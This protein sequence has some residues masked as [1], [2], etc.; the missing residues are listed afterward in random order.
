MF[1][2]IVSGGVSFF[3]FRKGIEERD[4]VVCLMGS[5]SIKKKEVLRKEKERTN[6]EERESVE[7]Y[8]KF[9]N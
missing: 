2:K 4:E 6:L 3:F 8:R 9:D 7:T 1:Y 5:F